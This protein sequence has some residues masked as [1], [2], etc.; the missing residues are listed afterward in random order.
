MW[1]MWGVGGLCPCASLEGS[2]TMLGCVQL[3]NFR[4]IVLRGGMVK[5]GGKVELISKRKGG[6]GF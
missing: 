2:S 4:W 1:K 6:W 3:K 5:G